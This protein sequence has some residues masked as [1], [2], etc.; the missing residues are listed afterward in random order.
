MSNAQLRNIGLHENEISGDGVNLYLGDSNQTG[1]MNSKRTPAA[2]YLRVSSDKQDVGMQEEYCRSMANMD[3]WSNDEIV[4]YSDDG[5]SATK[6]PDLLNR[7]AGSALIQDIEAG[8][9]TH[10]Y[11][12]RVDRLFRNLGAGAAFLADCK[13]KWP[14]LIIR[15]AD[16]PMSLTSA[17]G[18]F[19]FGLNVLL[20]RR[21]AAVLSVR[22]Q[23]GMQYTADNLGKVSGCIWGWQEVNGRME[24]HWHQQAVLEW[25]QSNTTD[26]NSKI[27]S[28]IN[29]CGIKTITGRK[30]SQSTVWRM[31]KTPPKY[32]DQ[33]HQ[34]TRPQRMISYPFR[35]YK[36]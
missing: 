1:G 26:S 15:T 18:E 14:H 22:T 16:A 10:V 36:E 4:I 21:E 25:I 19:L 8:K 32:Q 13:N 5:Q 28:R 30:F 3:G 2:L 27:A 6:M 12:Y 17:D 24:P 33:L 7:P 35:T 34:F 9:I 31:K 20:A 23:G 11:A 29:A